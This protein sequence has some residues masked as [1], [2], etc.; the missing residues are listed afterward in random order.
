MDKKTNT[1]SSDEAPKK[2]DD[3][4][5]PSGPVMKGLPPSLK[6]GRQDKMESPSESPRKRQWTPELQMQ[7]LKEIVTALLAFLIV[8][9]TLV[10]VWHSFTYVGDTTKAGDAKD[11]LTIMSGLAGVVVG[12]YFGRVSA[13]ARASQA[14]AK[15]DGALSQN[16]HL[17]A[18]AQSIST[19]L[20]HVIDNS[21]PAMTGDPKAAA[22][23]DQLRSLRD[24]LSELTGSTVS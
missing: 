24:E 2:S 17:K 3:S 21:A 4:K 14:S 7:L 1:Q 8:I 10:I 18:K 11:L 23:L 22:S 13:D 12:Y 19:G 6:G 9:Y 20:N 16:A 15:A 5:D